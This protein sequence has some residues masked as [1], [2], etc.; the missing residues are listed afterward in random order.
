VESYPDRPQGR[1]RRVDD[2]WQATVLRTVG[3]DLASLSRDVCSARAEQEVPESVRDRLARIDDD[4]RRLAQLADDVVAS[5]PP[6]DTV[7]AH[8]AATRLTRR[9]WQC[10]E[11]MV[12]GMNTHAM[13]DR[14]G[15]SDATVRTHAQA[16]LAKLGVNSR[17]QA[18][19]LTIRTALLRVAP[20]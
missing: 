17:L 11:L 19:A 14:L 7:A 9:E 1:G 18:V 10:L 6:V 3:A 5:G 4:L 2:V 20:S 15:V 16:V 12:G 8:R 13:A